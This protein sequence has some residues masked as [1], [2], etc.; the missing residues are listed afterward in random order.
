M[1]P[2]TSRERVPTPMCGEVP[3]SLCGMPARVSAPLRIPGLSQRTAPPVILPQPSTP[4]AA[5][6]VALTPRRK[7]A[8]MRL[9]STPQHFAATPSRIAS[10]MRV[11]STPNTRLDRLDSVAFPSLE[12]PEIAMGPACSRETVATP[13]CG[14]VPM[15]LRGM[16]APLRIP[17]LSQRAALP[18]RQPQPSTASTSVALTAM[19]GAPGS[20]RFPATPSQM[21]SSVWPPSPL[22]LPA[23]TP[24]HPGTPMAAIACTPRR[25]AMPAEAETPMR[26]AAHC[27][28]S[29]QPAENYAAGTPRAF[30]V[31]PIE[32]QASA[33]FKSCCM[34]PPPA[35]SRSFQSPLRRHGICNAMRGLTPPVL[36]PPTA[37]APMVF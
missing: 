18:A 12:A 25:G 27:S 8:S 21:A 11:P 20:H 32:L 2:A 6:S 29:T 13:M 1:G 4:R 35:T 28:R 10:S 7:A 33:L 22:G 16:A 26:S 5:T 37:D 30:V 34:P 31:P 17:G 23:A 24:G 36:L 14:E 3:V 19:A 15:A 9:P